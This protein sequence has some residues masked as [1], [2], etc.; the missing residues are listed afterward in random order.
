MGG[1]N[2]LNDHHHHHHDDD[3]DRD[4]DPDHD[5]DHGCGC[6]FYHSLRAPPDSGD[7]QPVMF[8]VDTI[9]K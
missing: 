8:F 2:G 7:E 3:H 6:G 9:G 5:R 1:P 4:P